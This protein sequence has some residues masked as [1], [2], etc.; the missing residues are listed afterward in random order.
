MVLQKEI[1]E[2]QKRISS[3]MDINIIC[4]F[5]DGSIDG[6]LKILKFADIERFFCGISCKSGYTEKYRGRIE[7]IKRKYNGKSGLTSI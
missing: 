2:I 7:S 3:D 4:D 1:D 5:C 6:K